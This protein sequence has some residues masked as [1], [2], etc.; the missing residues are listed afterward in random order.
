MSIARRNV[1]FSAALI[2]VGLAACGRTEL[3]VP[4]EDVSIPD[5]SDVQTDT[6]DV[7]DAVCRTNAEC[8]DRV[9]CNGTEQ[10][11]AGVCRPGIPVACDDGVECTRDSC[12]EGMGGTCSNVPD[13]SRCTAPATCDLRRGCTA[14]MCRTNEECDDRNVCN[15]TEQCVAGACVSSPPPVCNDGIAC[16]ED[17]CDPRVGC[18][19]IPDNGRC[20]DG[21]FCNG[22]EQ[23]STAA[24]GCVGSMPILCEDGNPCTTERCDERTRSCLVTGRGDNDNDGFIS[25]RCGGNDCDDTNGTVNPGRP[26]GVPGT[27][28]D[29]L[30][31]NCDGLPDCRDSRCAMTAE[32]AACMPTGPEGPPG[33]CRDGRDNNCNRLADCAD[34]ACAMSPECLCTPTGP[35]NNP[36]ACRDGRDNDCDGRLDCADPECAGVPGCV[37][38]MPT[39]PEGAGTTCNDGRDND[40]NGALDCADRACAMN[41]VCVPTNE[42]CATA[43]PI[44]LPGSVSGTTVGAR[45]DFTP[46]CRPMGMAG[47]VVWVFNNPVRQTIVVDTIGSSYDTVLMVRRDN[48]LGPDLSCDD[49]SGGGANSRIV[50]A[51]ALPGRYFVI[52]DGFGGSTGAY[53]LN[54][55]LG[56]REVCDNRVDD[57]GDG[58]ADCADTDCAAFPACM[59]CVPVARSETGFCA[60]GRDED[61]DRLVDC[62]DPDCRLDPACMGCVPMGP[63]NNPVACSDGRDNDC[64]RQLDCA[65][66]DCRGVPGCGCVPTGPESNPMACLDGRDNDC[67][68]RLDCADPECAMV[69]ACV[70]CMPTGP[71][72]TAAACT[73]G[74]DNDCDRAIDCADSECASQLACCRPSGPENT[75]AACSDRRDNDCDGRV[76]CADPE[77]SGVGMCACVVSPEVCNDGRDNDCDRLIDCMDPSCSADP[78]CMVCTPTGPEMGDVA[79]ADGRD[80]DCDR[81]TDCADPQCSSAFVCCRATGSENTTATCS[82]GMDNDCD[83]AVDCMD[84][85][86]AMVPPCL[87]APANDT[88]AGAQ[89]VGVP[90]VTTGS[91]VGARN[92]FQPV[93]MG[94]PGCAGGS[95]PDVVYT[96]SVRTRTPI[97]VD[98]TGMGFDAVAFVRRAPCEM[99]A[100]LACNDD[101]IGQNPRVAFVADPGQYFVFVDGFSPMGQGAFT[102]SISVGLPAENC[103]NG[104]DDDADGLSDCADPDCR[105][106]P[107]CVVCMPTGPENT[108]A[109]CGDG[110]DNDCDMLT[111]CADSE[112]ASQ[113]MCCRPTGP[114]SGA[115]ACSDGRDNDCNRLTDCADPSCA[116]EPVC[117]RPTGPEN[118]AA[119]CSDGRDNDCDRLTD[120]ADPQC[121]SLPVCCRPTG[122]E[123]G[124]A[125]CTDGRDNDC[126]GITDCADDGCTPLRSQGSTECCNGRDD[127]ANSLVDE[128]ACGCATNADCVGVGVGGR[129]PSPA[130]YLEFPF[131]VP[132]VCGIDC[133][134]AGGDAFCNSFGAEFSC[135]AMTGACTR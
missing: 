119:A 88:C 108:A 42:D 129:F 8:D 81:L 27:C 113:P 46:S 134:A 83:R 130:C 110:R 64:D 45:D 128:F 73:D 4:L 124:R 109:A 127:D 60:G 15:G 53:R 106:D 84:P 31:N 86:C 47:D 24:R 32:C 92:D 55:S 6:P 90:S 63:E 59:M 3:E 17:R 22:V 29:G 77:C 5:A 67:D 36:L 135:N 93:I 2:A 14:T 98:V 20:D 123:S 33:T 30:D 114:E 87:A 48:C 51:D 50:L 41:P 70:V 117:C 104:R 105:M 99:G 7:P 10:C 40:C 82:D 97:T 43:R 78:A 57:D 80:N 115:M 68:G 89:T 112:C 19:A 62:A 103:G 25:V 96:F 131:M 9:F 107:R 26:E 12:D 56:V 54:I 23:C 79:C 38:C 28:L 125:A 13:N 49:D 120:C 69:P 91:T 75:D 94:F 85:G 133:R 76:D 71:E 1:W 35:E 74:R 37:M 118:T 39:G 116:A 95:G 18:V 72:N 121:Q 111:D 44:S 21:V 11:V 52:V 58:L 34:P 100:Q 65:D 66:P 122:P 101:T 61:C 126:D 102:L 132:P 16:T